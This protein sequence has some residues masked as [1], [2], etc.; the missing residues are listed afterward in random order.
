[1]LNILIRPNGQSA[2]TAFPL[3]PRL[4]HRRCAL[5]GTVTGADPLYRC[6]PAS[7]RALSH[8]LKHSLC[9]LLGGGLSLSD[10]HAHDSPIEQDTATRARSTLCHAYTK[11]TP[12]AIRVHAFSFHETSEPSAPGGRRVGLTRRLDRPRAARSARCAAPPPP[13]SPRSCGAPLVQSRGCAARGRSR[14]A[15]PSPRVA[16]SDPLRRQ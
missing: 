7:C 3:F 1:M 12:R 4:W 5:S 6:D 15:A 13:R 10:G 11:H 8:S 2:H 14:P 9:E 16:T